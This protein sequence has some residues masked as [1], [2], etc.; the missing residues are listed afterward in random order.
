MVSH[1]PRALW[2]RDLSRAQQELEALLRASQQKLASEG[3]LRIARKEQW[4]NRLV[5]E[6]YAD[7]ILVISEIAAAMGL[8]RSEVER[9]IVRAGLPAESRSAYHGAV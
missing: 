7:R 6:A 4:R 3:L 9:I 8:S 2:E 5:C 1:R